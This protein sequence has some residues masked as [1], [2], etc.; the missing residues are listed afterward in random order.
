[1]GH[2]H[3]YATRARPRTPAHFYNDWNKD[4]DS[5]SIVDERRNRSDDHHNHNGERQL[6]ISDRSE[7]PASNIRKSTRTLYTRRQNQNS[8]YGNCCRMAK[9]GERFIWCQ[10]AGEKQRQQREQR[11]DIGRESLTNEAIHCR[12]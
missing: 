6:G 1:M 7:Q 12:R 4:S 11:R 5:S 3:Q 2:R 8:R 9:S 10:H